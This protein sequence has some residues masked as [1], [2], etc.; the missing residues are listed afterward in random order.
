MIVEVVVSVWFGHLTHVW[1]DHK[2]PQEALVVFG[3][4]VAAGG[5]TVRHVALPQ[6]K[7][8]LC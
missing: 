2:V 3:D 4:A 5:D 7:H 1:V 6:R 8:D